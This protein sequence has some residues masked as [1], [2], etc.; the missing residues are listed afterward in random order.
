MKKPWAMGNRKQTS[1]S[2]AYFVAVILLAK[3]VSLYMNDPEWF[4]SRFT[5]IGFLIQLFLPLAAIAMLY[6]LYARLG[7]RLIKGDIRI[8]RLQRLDNN[9][10]PA[11]ESVP[12]N[13]RDAD[14]VAAW[15]KKPATL[16]SQTTFDVG[17]YGIQVELE[18]GKKRAIYFNEHDRET[19]RGTKYFWHWSLT[20]EQQEAF[21]QLMDPYL[22]RLERDC[23]T[24]SNKETSG[25]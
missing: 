7:K 20:E 9:G 25:I 17:H 16:M 21:G 19:F 15:F 2:G 18:S 24:D 14:R 10:N 6:F 3:A 22:K 4:R 12:L 8:M 11:G 13:R 23:H 1:W 5:D